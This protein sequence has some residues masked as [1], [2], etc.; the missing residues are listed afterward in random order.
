MNPRELT[1]EWYRRIWNDREP[2]AIE[3]MMADDA[4]M[5]GL[6]IIPSGKEGFRMFR[7]A[8]LNLFDDL[9]AKLKTVIVEGNRSSGDAVFE[10]IH[11]KTG[12]PISVRVSFVAT[13]ENNQL[14]A[15]TNVV[16]YLSLLRQTG[17]ADEDV[18]E[19]VLNNDDAANA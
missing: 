17:F 14:V 12:Q 18:L 2:G 1:E 11:K 7:N 6:E 16:D 9:E 13:W 5:G 15:G 8:V 10:G 3:E 19:Q 4:N